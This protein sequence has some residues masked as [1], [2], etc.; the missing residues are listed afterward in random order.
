MLFFSMAC[1][2]I[3]SIQFIGLVFQYSTLHINFSN[4][5]NQ[6]LCAIPVFSHIHQNNN[7]MMLQI[8]VTFGQIP[9]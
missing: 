8:F 9:F 1:W 3:I 7:K 5:E 4:E 2:F 6:I